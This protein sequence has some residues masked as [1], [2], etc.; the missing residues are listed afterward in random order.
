VESQH[1]GR[2]T[3]AVHR[4]FTYSQLLLCCRRAA[5]CCSC[6]SNLLPRLFT[7][8]AASF[9]LLLQEG[10]EVLFFQ[11][12]PKGSKER[13]FAPGITALVSVAKGVRA[14][15]NCV[16]QQPQQLLERLISSRFISVQ[17]GTL[18]IT[19]VQ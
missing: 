17:H 7:R 12:P 4:L 6:N 2:E 5:R 9:S 15:M 8:L 16:W 10:D 19:L 3:V 13:D 14:G 18:L 11:S 1:L